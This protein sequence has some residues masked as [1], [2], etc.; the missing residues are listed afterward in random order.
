MKNSRPTGISEVPV[1]A[2]T[3]KKKQLLKKKSVL[4]L[5]SIAGIKSLKRPN[6]VATIK[7]AKSL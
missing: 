3:R 1:P 6:V 4:P 2:G 7:R 5:K